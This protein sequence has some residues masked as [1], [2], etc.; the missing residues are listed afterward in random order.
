[1]KASLSQLALSMLS[2][3][4]L[5]PITPSRTA[6]L[7]GRVAAAKAGIKGLPAKCAWIRNQTVLTM[8]AL[9]RLDIT[10]VE[11][12]PEF[13]KHK[14]ELI[15]MGAWA[16]LARADSMKQNGRGVLASRRTQMLEKRAMLCA[17]G[18]GAGGK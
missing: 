7:A 9:K 6:D 13:E 8:R 12:R 2:V 3:R 17:T 1:M 15:G 18:L 4:A 5:V 11:L 14:T 16:R 10:W